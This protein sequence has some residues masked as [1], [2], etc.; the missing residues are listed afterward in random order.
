M[1]K[2][3]QAVPVWPLTLR[4]LMIRQGLLVLGTGIGEVLLNK[5]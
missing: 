4:L 1:K 2:Q 5:A 3:V